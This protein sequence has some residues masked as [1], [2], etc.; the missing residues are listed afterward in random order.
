MRYL[1]PL[2]LFFAAAGLACVVGYNLI[3][4]TV[5]AQGVLHEPF[6]LIPIG[7]ACFLLAG[8]FGGWYLLRRIFRR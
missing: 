3:G 8:I 4:S 7:W 5:D 6:G 1:L 2:A